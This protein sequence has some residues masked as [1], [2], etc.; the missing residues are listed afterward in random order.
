[1]RQGCRLIPVP[2][3]LCTDS[4]PPNSRCKL[5]KLLKDDKVTTVSCNSLA[6]LHEKHVKDNATVSLFVP[7][8]LVTGQIHR[9]LI[10]CLEKSEAEEDRKGKSSQRLHCNCTYFPLIRWFFAARP[11]DLSDVRAQ[12]KEA[13]STLQMDCAC[14]CSGRW[15]RGKKEEEKEKNQSQRVLILIFQWMQQNVLAGYSPSCCTG[16]PRCCS[17]PAW[18]R[19]SSE[20]AGS[21]PLPGRRRST[22]CGLSGTEGDGAARP[23]HRRTS[24]HFTDMFFNTKSKLLHSNYGWS[25]TDIGPI[26]AKSGCF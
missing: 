25:D 17:P 15:F 4:R 22:A 1:M 21:S 26:S 11:Q 9:F 5:T 6:H 14:S 24:K 8:F 16:T 20:P 2:C 19:W 23:A 12:S 3:G 10:I 7:D 13:D 18:R